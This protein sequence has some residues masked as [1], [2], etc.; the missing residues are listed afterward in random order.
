MRIRLVAIGCRLNSGEMDA[1]ARDFSAAGHFVVPSGTDADL[2]VIN[3]C[4]V[5][6]RAGA[7]SRRIIRRLRRG[8]A[9]AALVV[10]GCYAQL[11]AQTARDLGADLVV[12]NQYKDALPQI[13]H[14]AGLLTTPEPLP[15]QD[16]AMLVAAGRTRAFLKVQDGCHNRCAFCVV[17]LARG[18]ARSR[19]QRIVVADINRLVALGYHEVVL[20]G[21]HLGA[22]GH[23]HGNVDGLE[24]L[25]E[26]VLSET[27]IPRLRLS[28]LEPW[29]LQPSFFRHWENT[30]LLP[31]LHLPLQSGCDQTLR[32]MG[33]RNT[34]TSFRTLLQ[35]ARS[36][37]PD[38]GVSADIMVGFPGE[39]DAEF[40]QSLEFAES[41]AFAR[42]HIFRYSRRA[43]TSAAKMPAQV[44][45]SVAKERSRHLHTLDVRMQARFRR[46]FVG[47][48]LDVL[49][50]RAQKHGD[51]LCWSGL[52]PNYLRV[53]TYTDD[54]LNLHNVMTETS[55]LTA[56]EDGLLGEVLAPFDP[57]PEATPRRH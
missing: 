14:E 17:T 41:M 49:W 11:S 53:L 25:V 35:A 33:R 55:M 48:K 29:D 16:V 56:V 1:L 22:Y 12:G 21:V 52:T 32:R 43:G 31:H 19:A 38:L 28:S 4:T 47:R 34:C 3:T 46:K 42:M 39:S 20:C 40:K 13:L 6:H 26:A 27:D 36:T 2:V 24:K 23:D 10:T 15:A 45:A 50:E 37:I 30:R 9:Q 18:R 57:S 8:H 51:G 44:S 54:E 5:T 7:D